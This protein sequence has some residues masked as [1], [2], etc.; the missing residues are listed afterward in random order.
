MAIAFI[1]DRCGDVFREVD[2]KAFRNSPLSPLYNRNIYDVCNRFGSID[3][4]PDL[5]PIC[6][7]KLNAWMKKYKE[8]RKS[9]FI[10][11][12]DFYEALKDISGLPMFPEISYDLATKFDNVEACGNNPP[13]IQLDDG[14]PRGPK[15]VEDF[16]DCLEPGETFDIFKAI[17]REMNFSFFNAVRDLAGED[18]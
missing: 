12:N 11:P 13:V 16:V 14:I 8:G 3:E 4:Q 2:D 9:H 17:A 7:L 1:C 5:C 10:I 6:T 15:C 18:K